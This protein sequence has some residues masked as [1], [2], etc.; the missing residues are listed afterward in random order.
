MSRGAGDGRG[1]PAGTA[2]GRSY[3]LKG[4]R[5]VCAMSA[6]RPVIG[7]CAALE[8]ARWSV[9]DLRAALLPYNYVRRCSGLAGSR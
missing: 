9:W 1:I 6:Q 4:L 8:R 3:G 7:M 5:I 2:H